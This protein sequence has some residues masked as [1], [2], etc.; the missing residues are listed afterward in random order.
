MKKKVTKFLLEL[1]MTDL[2]DEEFLDDVLDDECV[3]EYKILKTDT[4][5]A[6]VEDY[7]DD[8]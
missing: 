3:H 4:V 8:D 7:E 1:T 6:D 5:I 2:A